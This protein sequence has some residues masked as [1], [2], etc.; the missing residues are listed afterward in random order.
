MILWYL[1]QWTKSIFWF[2]VDFII[3]FGEDIGD[4]LASSVGDADDGE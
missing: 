2:L 1:W 3:E 4:L